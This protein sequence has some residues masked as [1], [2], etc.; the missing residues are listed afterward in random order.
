MI[1][2]NVCF[3]LSS[4]CGA[5]T[6]VYKMLRGR[7]SSIQIL[8]LAPPDSCLSQFKRPRSKGRSE[9]IAVAQDDV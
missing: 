3:R 4:M 6:V 5:F 8:N 2:L 1:A 7:G 9:L